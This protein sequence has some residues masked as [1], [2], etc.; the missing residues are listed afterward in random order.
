MASKRRIELCWVAIAFVASRVLLRTLT[1]LRF[2]LRPIDTSWHIIDPALL[3]DDLLRSVFHTPA[4]PPLYNL[5]LGGVLKLSEDQ[6]V[7]RSL[8][9]LLFSGMSLLSTVFLFDLL[10]RLRFSVG[11]CSLAAAAFAM[12]P[13]VILYESLPYYTMIVILLLVLMA[14]LFQRCVEH[15][16]IARASALWWSAAALIYVRSLFQLPWLLVLVAAA[17][18]SVR[19]YTRAWCKAAI[20]PLSCVLLLYGKNL[21]ISGHFQT[22][23]WLGMSAVKLTVHPLP[24]AVRHE[25]IE[26][27]R[28]SPLAAR[29]TT[30]DPPDEHPA[31]FAATRKTGVFV[32]DQPYKS[33][34]H[35]N[36]H[37][38][39]YVALSQ[40]ALA[41]AKR[42]AWLFPGSYLRS[43]GKAWVMSFRPASDYPYLRENRAAIEPWSRFHA[44]FFSGQARYPE[45]PWFSLDVREVGYLAVATYLA[46]V[47]FGLF[48]AYASVATGRVRARDAVYLFMWLSVMYVGFVGNAFEIGENQRFRLYSVPFLWCLNLEL[49]RRVTQAVRARTWARTTSRA[50]RL[51]SP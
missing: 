16:T 9:T 3:R 40:Q 42:A 26:A 25:L 30:Y 19:G 18:W 47:L 29:D 15:F 34:G 1:D 20:L 6:D 27:G 35:V 5:L 39:A 7:L 43:M 8:F 14:W 49:L 41:D 22:S 4:Q 50:N 2:D 13:A 51:S 33:T 44:R 21:W 10:R 31:L 17:A 46:G 32:L 37:H 11:L 28:L 48:V 36:L 23:S 45:S 24:H 38:L 12:S